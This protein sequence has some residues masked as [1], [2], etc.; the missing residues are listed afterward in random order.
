[1]EPGTWINAC[2][3]FPDALADPFAPTS[4]FGD[5]IYIGLASPKK[6]IRI[7]STGGAVIWG[8]GATTMFP[9]A[10]DEVRN[11]VLSPARRRDRLPGAKMVARRFGTTLVSVGG[12]S[13]RAISA[14][15]IFNTIYYALLNPGRNGASA[16]APISPSTGRLRATD[17]LDRAGI[18]RM[19]QIG[20]CR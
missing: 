11:R 16:S 4:G 2:P 12:D 3:S 9:T 10:S 19:V 17:Q 13:K 5:M 18:S 15:P 6:A 1:L 14:S 20:S 8:V 7:E